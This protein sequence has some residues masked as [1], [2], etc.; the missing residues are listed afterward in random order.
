MLEI[1]N[2]DPSMKILVT[3][4]AG[5][6][7]SHLSESLLK[8][9]H[10]VTILDNLSLGNASN[11]IHVSDKVNFTEGDIRDKM[12]VNSL[13][14]NSDIVFH[15]AAALGVQNIINNTLESISVNI[16]GSE[17]VLKSAANYNKQIVIASTSEIYGKNIKQ[18][19]N[20]LDDRV[21]GAPQVSRWSY[22]DA[23]A[24]EEHMAFA[25]AKSHG[26]KF[27]TIRFFNIVGP[28]QIGKYG[29]VVPRFVNQAIHN[30]PIEVYGNGNQKRVFCHVHDAVDALM[31]IMIKKDAYGDVF[32]LGGN[33]E[34]SILELAV[35]IKHLTNSNSPIIFKEYGEIYSS[36]FEDMARRVPDISKI[37]R[38][39][40][41]EP[42]RNIDQ[43]V[44]DVVNLK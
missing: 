30:L 25:L 43:I 13:I 8:S 4:G 5:F 10:E 26:L 39:I 24:I 21:I 33:Q 29:M 20:E 7:G 15:F 23:K 12:L 9:G 38:I 35:R 40:D 1:F 22:S 19:L 42:L 34:L 28:R 37:Q 44:N 17:V 11:L 14:E 32:N 18:P 36:G 3:G 6:I 2:Y 16:E 41:W 27:I 31:K